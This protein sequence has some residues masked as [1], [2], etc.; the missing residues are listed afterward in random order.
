MRG[1]KEHARQTQPTVPDAGQASGSSGENS[2]QPN[3][4]GSSN[5]QQTVP[6]DQ[7]GNSAR[8]TPESN[9]GIYQDILVGC[10]ELVE[11]YRK[12]EITKPTVYVEIQSKLFKALG[13]DRDRCDAAFGSFIATIESHDSENEAAARRGAAV[14]QEQRSPSPPISN[15]D[16][17]DPGSDGEPATKKV[18][19]DESTFAW[20]TNRREKRTVLRESLAKTLQLIE[21]YTV[22][23][24][25]TK[26]SLINEPDCP[27]FPD[28]EWK[29]IITGR[30]VN[31]DA[32]L[33][34]QLSTTHNDTKVEKFGELEIS[35]GAVE[36]TKVV[37]N[38]GDWTIAW[39][40]T[41]RATT[42]AFPSPISQNS[43][44]TENTS[45]TF[46]QSLTPVSIAGSSHSIKPSAR[47]WEASGTS[48]YGISRNM[49]I[50][51]SRTWIRLE[52]QSSRDLLKEKEAE[53]GRRGRIGREMS[54]ATSGT[55]ENAVKR[56]RTAGDY[57]SVISAKRQDTREKSVERPRLVPDRPR[58]LQRSVWTD[59]GVSPSLSPT[60][61]CTQFD[62]PLPRPPEEEFNNS[63]A[64]TTI[65]ENSHLFKIITPINVNRFEELLKTHPNQSFVNSVCVSLREGFWPWANTQREQ[66]PITW[67]FSNRPPKTE[68]EADFLRVRG[69]LRLP[70]G[71]T[72]KDL[73]S[74]YCQ[75][76]TAHL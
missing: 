17:L 71:D 22:D 38:G 69:M 37:K 48:S 36:P 33:S 62:E 42:Y 12:G 70:Q 14:N 6:G 53:R 21:I 11:R 28:S 24:K 18:K 76:C 29:N 67:D 49:P 30:A 47:E 19:V 7:S 46:S 39:N 44:D 50:S 74:T 54:R 32:V 31:L 9:A 59:A 41:V 25:A 66:Y 20:N 52:Y 43:P 8:A 57:T 1:G 3:N 26:R 58:Y 40:R 61:G 51:K 35:F 68:R 34:G 23:P 75:A 10:N 5:T 64:L 73:G 72:Q 45:S 60:A 55:M 65:R 13:K 16:E 2:S 4:S 56:K 15:P 27:E 63:E